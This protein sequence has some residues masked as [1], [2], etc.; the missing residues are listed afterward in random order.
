MTLKDAFKE[1]PR[2]ESMRKESEK[3][4]ELLSVAKN[5]EGLQRHCSTH[6]AGV[7]ISSKALTNFLPLYKFPS[8]GKSEQD[9][10]VTQYSM[11][12]VEKLGLLK[13][14]FLGL[15]TLT[16]IDNALRLIKESINIDLDITAIPM[17]DQKT[18]ELLC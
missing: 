14:D 10:V 7:V 2:F 16:V 3:V 1:E 15:K 13:M 9:E 8:K 4:A 11:G 6:A 18:F 12:S 5:L 17:D